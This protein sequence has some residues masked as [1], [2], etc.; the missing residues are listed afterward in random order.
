[1]LP[2]E[3]TWY[4]IQENN[5]CYTTVNL[6][7]T[8]FPLFL[9]ERRDQSGF[10]KTGLLHRKQIHQLL[11]SCVSDKFFSRSVSCCTE[12]RS[13]PPPK[14]KFHFIL[15]H[16]AVRPNARCS[17]LYA[18]H[19]TSNFS[20]WECGRWIEGRLEKTAAAEAAAPTNSQTPGRSLWI[21]A[22]P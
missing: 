13:Q 6:S 3:S 18:T 11:L 21:L 15:Q 17:R 4:I 14:F 7:C 8:M 9:R 16:R 22:W 12:P 2:G 5:L 19:K 10:I 1:M 20:C